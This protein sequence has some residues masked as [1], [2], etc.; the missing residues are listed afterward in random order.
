MILEKIVDL[1][2]AQPGTAARSDEDMGAWM[3]YLH[4]QM[5]KPTDAK[6]VSVVLLIQTAT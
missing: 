2:P 5:P 1:S 6:G 4:R 3:E